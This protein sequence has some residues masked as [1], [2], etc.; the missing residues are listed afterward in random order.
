[1]WHD[2]IWGLTLSA[3][4]WYHL[5]RVSLRLL[6]IKW[7]CRSPADNV[8]RQCLMSGH[9]TRWLDGCAVSIAANGIV[10]SHPPREWLHEPSRG[11]FDT[12]D[13]RSPVNTRLCQCKTF[14]IESTTKRAF[15]C[16]V[17][18]SY[19]INRS[20]PFQQKDGNKIDVLPWAFLWRYTFSLYI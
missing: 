6:R 10:M 5:A 7:C 9:T 4:A 16:S 13:S 2:T 20:L 3:S 11:L 19:L 12:A 1:M 8:A 15:N 17:M 18:H 14:E